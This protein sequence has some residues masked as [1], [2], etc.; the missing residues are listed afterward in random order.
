M[1]TTPPLASDGTRLAAKVRAARDMLSRAACDDLAYPIRFINDQFDYV[2]DGLEALPDGTVAVEADSPITAIL[3]P[4]NSEGA[5]LLY[6][7]ALAHSRAS[8]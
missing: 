2:A 1:K 7:A 4:S 8:A 6:I 3:G 5:M